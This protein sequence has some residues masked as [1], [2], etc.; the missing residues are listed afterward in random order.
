MLAEQLMFDVENLTLLKLQGSFNS[1]YL[2]RFSRDECLSDS[3][4]KYG[5]G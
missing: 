5:K 1:E 3:N 2:V 4:S